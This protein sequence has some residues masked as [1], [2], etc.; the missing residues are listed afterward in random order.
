MARILIID[1][2]KKL[3]NSLSRMLKEEGYE[4]HAVFTAEEAIILFETHSIDVVVAQ[5]DLPG[6][7][8]IELVEHISDRGLDIK[9]ILLTDKPSMESV[10]AATWAGAFDYLVRPVPHKTLSRVVN[11][12]TKVKSLYSQKAGDT[13][14]KSTPQITDPALDA[15]FA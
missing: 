5:I 7:S 10:R 3:Q 15:Q 11:C 8:G 14:V 4:A 13:P 12:A 2:E 9:T 6:R 1:G